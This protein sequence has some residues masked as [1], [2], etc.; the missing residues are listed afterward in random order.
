MRT[1]MICFVV[2]LCTVV[3]FGQGQP[4]WTVIQHVNLSQQSQPIP[5][6]TLLTPTEPGIYRLTV[7]FSGGTGTGVGYWTE[8]LTGTDITGAPLGAN[9]NVLCREINWQWTPPMTISLK[10]QVP[11]TYSVV[12]PNGAPTCRYNLAITVEQLL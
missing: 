9:L 8:F 5:L 4:Q 1:A 7:Y 12:S 10:P 11:L 2:M 3:A 6:T